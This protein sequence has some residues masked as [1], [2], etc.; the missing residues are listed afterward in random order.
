MD[1]LLYHTP[2]P[3]SSNIYHRI[4]TL[5]HFGGPQTDE[6]GS[7]GTRMSQKNDRFPILGSTGPYWQF[8][9]AVFQVRVDWPHLIPRRIWQISGPRRNWHKHPS[10]PVEQVQ[11]ATSQSGLCWW[12]ALQVRPTRTSSPDT[13]NRYQLPVCHLS[14]QWPQVRLLPDSIRWPWISS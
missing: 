3:L 8:R 7:F 5:A 10:A 9:C 6:H 11:R 13:E 12:W 14:H 1:D 2:L 4:Q